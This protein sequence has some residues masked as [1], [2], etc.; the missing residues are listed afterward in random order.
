MAP[1]KAQDWS[2]NFHYSVSKEKYS[3]IKTITRQK[4]ST[5][6]NKKKLWC[7][8]P[9]LEYAQNVSLSR[10]LLQFNHAFC[11]GA[12]LTPARAEGYVKYPWTEW[13]SALDKFKKQNLWHRKNIGSQKAWIRTNDSVL[14]QSK[15]TRCIVKF[16]MVNGKTK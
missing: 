13:Y 4:I 8:F 11:S 16:I 3:S 9:N 14:K 7:R 5:S 10:K 2:K 1:I 15:Y 6:N 12:H